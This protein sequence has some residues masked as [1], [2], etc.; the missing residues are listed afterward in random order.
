MAAAKARGAAQSQARAPKGAGRTGAVLRSDARRRGS[1]ALPG[2][3]ESVSIARG[4]VASLLAEWCAQEPMETAVLLTSEVVTNAIL[5]AGSDVEM[6][7]DADLTRVRVSVTDG[8]S[9]RPVVVP[10][11][12]DAIG[13]RGLYLLDSLATRWGVRGGRHGKT[14]WFELGF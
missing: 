2:G 9:T 5:H 14:V 11:S 3:P 6:T 4:A 7:V 13:G 1:Y 8:S 10:P 12:L